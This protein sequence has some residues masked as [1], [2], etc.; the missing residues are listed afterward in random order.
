M[1]PIIVINNFGIFSNSIVHVIYI[2]VHQYHEVHK[3]LI[4]LQ[5]EHNLQGADT[6]APQ[7]LFRAHPFLL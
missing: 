4:I 3:I 5:I 6:L 7:V 2:I 1:G